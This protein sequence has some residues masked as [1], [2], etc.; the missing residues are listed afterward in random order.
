MATFPYTGKYKDTISP[1]QERH[2]MNTYRVVFQ[3]I[4]EDSETIEVEADSEQEAEQIAM[5]ER[6]GPS[7]AYDA[8]FCTQDDVYSVDELETADA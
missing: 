4:Y 2:I 3:Y 6:E 7:Y 8:P 5:D 1:R